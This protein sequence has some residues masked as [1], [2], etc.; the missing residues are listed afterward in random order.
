MPIVDADAR[1]IALQSMV[2]PDRA[3]IAPDSYTVH[4]FDG[5]PGDE[6]V[7]VADTTEVDD[8]LGGTTFVANG[9]AAATV[10]AD[11]FTFDGE[12]ATV[13][14]GFP[15]PTEAYP[16]TVTHFLMRSGGVDYFTA[17]LLEPLDVT[18]PGD[19]Y[20]VACTLFF[21]DAVAP[22]A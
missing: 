4:L 9:Y 17:P 2:G 10:S 19:V 14:A 12:L 15:A 8:G 20:V 16:A 18:D 1:T 13:L 21:D 3:A 11:D 6:G 5:D 7:E 22:P